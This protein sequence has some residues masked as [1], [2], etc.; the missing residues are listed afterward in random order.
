MPRAPKIHRIDCAVEVRD[1]WY[2]N[3]NAEGK[4]DREGRYVRLSLL[5]IPTRAGWR[6][7]A[8]GAD[9]FGLEKDFDHGD[10]AAAQE[11]YDLVRQVGPI[12]QADLLS[13]GF[14]PC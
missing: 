4:P 12:T 2:P 6:V 9:D 10:R 11:T 8:W 13:I 7:C 3:F 1:D 5:E 14:H